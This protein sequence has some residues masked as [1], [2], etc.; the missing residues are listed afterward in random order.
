MVETLRR[1]SGEALPE[2]A[3]LKDMTVFIAL[4][5]RK[6]SYVCARISPNDTV[7]YDHFM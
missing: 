1:S 6:G 3:G 5:N 4:S 2:A 7:S